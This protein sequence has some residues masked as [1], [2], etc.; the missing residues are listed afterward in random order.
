[1]KRGK[2]MQGL[3]SGKT[4]NKTVSDMR[5]ASIGRGLNKKLSVNGNS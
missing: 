3:E 1:M 5:Y 2:P 4:Q